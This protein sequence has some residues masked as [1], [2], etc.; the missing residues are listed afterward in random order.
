MKNGTK[1]RQT[2]VCT[3]SSLGLLFDVC[4]CVCVLVRTSAG[5]RG[6][7]LVTQQCLCSQVDKPVCC[8]NQFTKHSVVAA[9]SVQVPCGLEPGSSA[10]FRLGFSTRPSSFRQSPFAALQ[11][12]P[13][14][15][16]ASVFPP[17][18]THLLSLKTLPAALPLSHLLSL[19]ESQ[20]ECAE[21]REWRPGG[22]RARLIWTAARFLARR[23][24]VCKLTW[25]SPSPVSVAVALGLLST[26]G[27]GAPDPGVQQDGAKNCCLSGVL[28]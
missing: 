17:S 1:A 22:H 9:L 27:G 26:M 8:T 25:L 15:A 3:C 28:T 21:L 18:L 13:F 19:A 6:W 24:A 10:S 7:T 23:R 12:F 4:V 5:S 16:V 2:D 11:L 14:S 20:P